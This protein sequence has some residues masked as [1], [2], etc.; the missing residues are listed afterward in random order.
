MVDP[1]LFEWSDD[2]GK[3]VSAH[4]PFT[5]PAGDDLNPATARSRG[6][7]LV[8]NGY[9]VGGGSIRIHDPEVQHRVFEVLGLSDVEIEE[10]FGHLLRAFRYGVPPHGGIAMGLDRIVMLMADRDTIRDVTAFPKAQSG[11]D[12]LTGAPAPVAEDQLREVGIRVVATPERPA[13]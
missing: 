10:K 13:R 5:A 2:E 3:W 12:P 7:D 11:A 9:E 1:P 4:H 6:Y 8:L